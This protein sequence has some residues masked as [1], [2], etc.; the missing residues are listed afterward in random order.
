MKEYPRVSCVSTTVLTICTE[1]S[2]EQSRAQL[3]SS[4]QSSS[5]CLR[6]YVSWCY[7][8]KWDV[9]VMCCC[10]AAADSSMCWWK[11]ITIVYHLPPP[12]PIPSYMSLTHHTVPLPNEMIFIIWASFLAPNIY[13]NLTKKLPFSCSWKHLIV[14]P[15]SPLLKGFGRIMDKFDWLKRKYEWILSH[16]VW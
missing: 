3:S 12:D 2:T 13:Y 16:I 1:L 10:S 4:E 14:T 5:K 9:Y 11:M 6:L 15:I 8:V 7:R